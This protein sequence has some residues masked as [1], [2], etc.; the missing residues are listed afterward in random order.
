MVFISSQTHSAPRKFRL[1]AGTA[2]ARLPLVLNG[3]IGQNKER[4][5]GRR[6]I[7][8]GWALTF[9]VVAIIAGLLGMS[10]VAVI[11]AQIAQFLF[12]L[13]LVLFAVAA[14]IAAINGRRPPAV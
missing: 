13:F 8:L 5:K 10:G 2:S 4:T 14:I 6:T 1:A 12:V 9:L 11:S 7:M 3:R